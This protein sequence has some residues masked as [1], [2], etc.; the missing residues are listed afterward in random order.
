M[1]WEPST[2][3]PSPAGRL[4]VL[5]AGGGITGL[6][7]AYEL[8]RSCPH[9]ELTLVDPNPRLGGHIQTFQRGGFLIDAGPDSFL[10]TKLEGKRLCEELGLAEQL[11]SPLPGAHRVFVAHKGRLVPLPAGMA[12][13]VPTRI[14]PMLTTPLLGVVD[15]LHVLS[16]LFVE[17]ASSPHADETVAAFLTRHFGPGVTHRIAGP[18]LGGIFAGDIEELSI[19][20][21][22]PQ[23]LAMEQE[24]GSLVRAV[25]ARDQMRRLRAE[26][27]PSAFEPNDPLWLFSLLR[28]MRREAKTG[29]SPFL[30]LRGGL[31]TLIDALH[32]QARPDKLRL[33]T[34]LMKVQAGAQGGY[35]A[36]LSDGTDLTVDAVI[37]AMPAY[38][39]ASWIGDE[40]LAE[41]LREVC[42]LS[43]ATAFFAYPKAALARPIEGAGFMVPLKEGRILGSTFVSAKWQGRAPDES[44]LLRV[45]LGGAREPEL[46]LGSDD[47]TLLAIA[48]SELSRL[49]GPLPTPELAEVYRWP[50][51]NAQPTV[52]HLGRMDRIFGRLAQMPGVFLAGSGYRAA[53]IAD[54]AA[55]GRAAAR[56]VLMLYGTGA[57]P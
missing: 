1:S 55:Q 33:R 19:A 22:F 53:G 8:R 31:A 32:A 52:G 30:T 49:L 28:W 54:C 38:A 21:T 42:Y 46:V 10:S 24:F 44:V 43:T 9:V 13:A 23:L 35:Q 20:A 6:S 3:S 41:E 50:K 56:Q 17:P 12:L 45:F 25:F 57:K 2:V 11:I 27:N 36:T 48:G 47:A 26:Q 34:S 16:D 37:G 51:A 18:L 14:G 5:V 15:K 29:P 7:A 39:A 40:Q 4:R